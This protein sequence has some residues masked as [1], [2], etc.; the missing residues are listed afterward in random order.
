MNKK[1]FKY[2]HLAPFMAGAL[3]TVASC[4]TTDNAKNGNNSELL[5]R[6]TR[7]Y[8]QDLNECARI[9]DK[10]QQSECASQLYD[11]WQAELANTIS[12]GGLTP[13]EVAQHKGLCPRFA[14]IRHNRQS[15][16]P[17]FREQERD[18][19]DQCTAAVERLRRR[20]VED[21]SSDLEDAQRAPGGEL[22]LFQDHRSGAFAEGFSGDEILLLVVGGWNS[23]A[24]KDNEGNVSF[25]GRTGIE[26]PW[27]G[28]TTKGFRVFYENHI[29]ARPQTK[30]NFMLIC[31][32]SGP[33]HIADMS[34][35]TSKQLAVV[36]ATID[37]R[38]KYKSS[39]LPAVVNQHFPNSNIPTYIVGHSYGGWVA[40]NFFPQLANRNIRGLFTLDPIS[41]KQC[42]PIVQVFQG[43][44]CT[45]APGTIPG[46]GD[47]SNQSIIN[48]MPFG[49]Q[50]INFWQRHGNLHSSAISELANSNQGRN[51]DRS[52]GLA[53]GSLEAA[54]RDMG[55]FGQNWD[56]ILNVVLSN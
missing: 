31:L 48:S 25:L 20:A 12:D 36:H 6:V 27:D 13:Q 4:K 43:G 45:V 26:S 30:I 23:C 10:I 24:T 37:G 15:H 35:V 1:V 22:A 49:A 33:A 29:N 44:G 17:G 39:D 34:F 7:P 9:R 42:P 8:A 16:G 47:I 55:R 32:H 46:G 52:S 19:R 5:A 51:I 38:Q 40:M 21:V 56:D 11:Q 14:N 50:W 54:H 53:S 3:M 18:F 2:G 28:R 41:S